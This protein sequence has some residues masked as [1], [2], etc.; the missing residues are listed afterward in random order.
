MARLPS[1]S[2]TVVEFDYSCLGI[3]FV[4]FTLAGLRP[5]GTTSMYIDGKELAGR[6]RNLLLSI[7]SLFL[8]DFA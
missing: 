7:V 6:Y 4:G 8:C 5:G 3:A 1:Q 2:F